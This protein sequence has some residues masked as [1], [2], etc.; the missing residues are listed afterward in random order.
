MY[1][2]MIEKLKEKNHKIEK[3]GYERKGGK[4]KRLM[5]MEEK[6]MKKLHLNE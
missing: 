6:K 4:V 1:H 5:K 2:K 3:M